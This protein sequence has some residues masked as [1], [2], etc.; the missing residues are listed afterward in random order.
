MRPYRRQRRAPGISSQL[1]ILLVILASWQVSALVLSSQGPIDIIVCWYLHAISLIFENT[2]PTIAITLGCVIIVI[3]SKPLFSLIRAQRE[4]NRL[5][6][7]LKLYTTYDGGA[8]KNIQHIEGVEVKGLPLIQFK[9]RERNQ[10]GA[11]YKYLHFE[12]LHAAI[13]EAIYEVDV[14]SSINIRFWAP[15]KKKNRDALRLLCSSFQATYRGL[16]FVEAPLTVIPSILG[17]PS[18]DG[19][20]QG[21]IA[22]LGR[23]YV[24]IIL[25]KGMPSSTILE[26]GGATQLDR[27][28]QALIEQE[29]EATFIVN[30][31]STK[32][33]SESRVRQPSGSSRGG[34]KSGRNRP[35]GE[36]KRDNTF[37]DVSAYLVV[38]SQDIKTHLEKVNSVKIVVE[39]IFSSPSF[40]ATILEGYALRW[41]VGRA[42]RRGKIGGTGVLSSRQL[43]ILVHLPCQAQPGYL[44]KHT[45]EF[46]LPPQRDTELILFN[47]MK[48]ERILY[49]AGINRSHLTTHMIVAGQTG[50]GKTRFVAHLLQQIRRKFPEIGITVFDW[51]GEYHRIM[52]TVYT[53]G[54]GTCPL[55]IN[56]F[57]VHGKEGAE[58]Y[59]Q[60]IVALIRELLHTNIDGVLSTQ[61]ERILR[62]SLV[63]YLKRGNGS[64]EGYEDFLAK[65]I[66]A[67]KERFSNP[68]ASVAGLLNRF[69]N[70]FR[71]RLGRIFNTT[72][73]TIDF[74]ALLRDHVC[75]D[76]S[77]L[78]AYNKEEARLFLNILL[79]LIR[80]YLFRTFSKTLRY[81]VVAEEAQYLIP[82]VFGKHSTADASPIEDI[83]L[84]QRAYGAG[85]I[86]I[87][88]RPSLISR[89]I[90]ANCGIKVFFQCPLDAE[91]VGDILNLNGEQRRYL[92][93]M[94]ERIAMA[95]V[96]WF[97]FPFKVQTFGF[98]LSR[99]EG[100]LRESYTAKPP[101]VE[102]EPR[103]SN[104]VSPVMQHFLDL[105]CTALFREEILHR[106]T[107]INGNVV[108]DIPRRGIIIVF[109][110]KDADM[111]KWLSYRE[112]DTSLVIFCPPKLKSIFGRMLKEW[113]ARREKSIKREVCIRPLTYS[114]ARQIA[115]QIRVGQIFLFKRCLTIK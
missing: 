32:A 66:Q 86:A 19:E 107:M 14:G 65:W 34:S 44:R 16:E 62:E 115:R 48:G 55:K 101:G 87:T 72:V 54:T 8:E 24:S 64:Y 84:F 80:A 97:D 47:V 58:G 83:A 94:P 95:H 57:E 63:D 67:N 111:H 3:L 102:R 114:E 79:M 9:P 85:L 29:I 93:L 36:T 2:F 30:F 39:T 6:R 26:G 59:A 43:A 50:K 105:V 21:K 20:I 89:N 41:A 75:F 103:Q 27:L 33:S 88:T 112:D 11:H 18:A 74:D 81:L 70:L 56:L 28:I 17:K 109:L 42:L 113:S 73:T 92:T 5:I 68:E 23:Q 7:W 10:K 108:I 71:G 82:E 37:W 49:P 69:G 4:W 38:K 52:K 45:T 22:R 99:K 98:E 12:A 96:P 35:T 1:V 78:A 61:M 13:R 40:K 110:D 104:M 31:S 53:V 25:L 46:E 90:L 15:H 60:N 106:V 77:E 100:S 76:L 51:K 91:L